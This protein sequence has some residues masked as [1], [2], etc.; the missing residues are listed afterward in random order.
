MNTLVHQHRPTHH[1][2]LAF[3]GEEINGWTGSFSHPSCPPL[4]HSVHYTAEQDC[5]GVTY[6]S[7]LNNINYSFRPD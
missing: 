1:E 3:C 5:V 2:I 7:P 6:T 4:L